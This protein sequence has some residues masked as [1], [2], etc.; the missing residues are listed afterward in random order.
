MEVDEKKCMIE[1][2]VAAVIARNFCIAVSK[3]E[4]ISTK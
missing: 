1:K 2:K 3:A 4:V